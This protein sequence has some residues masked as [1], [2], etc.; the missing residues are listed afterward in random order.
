MQPTF[1]TALSLPDSQAAVS[2]DATAQIK[3]LCRDLQDYNDASDSDTSD[4]DESDCSRSIGSEHES[5]AQAVPRKAF[6]PPSSKRQQLSDVEAV[7]IFKLRPKPRKGKSLHRGSMLLCKSIAPKYGVSP[8][9]IRDIWRGRTWLH[10]TQHLW[11]EEDMLYKSQMAAKCARHTL[12]KQAGVGD[13]KHAA[14]A[15]PW[16]AAAAPH[17][18]FGGA[19]HASSLPSTPCPILGQSRM[20]CRSWPPTGAP[21]F[22]MHSLSSAI[23][24]HAALLESAGR[25]CIPSTPFPPPP[26][27]WPACAGASWPAEAA[28]AA[29]ALP[30]PPAV[31]PALL[32]L[33]SAAGLLG[34]GGVRV[35]PCG[36]GLG[37]GGPLSAGGCFGLAR[38]GL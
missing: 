28:A 35:G 30:P 3:K 14:V 1:E 9:T 21:A 29:L 25:R 20:L 32:L 4:L 16:A 2:S 17:H 7:E 18:G 13:E 12:H 24:S 22:P 23:A 11:T 5:D 31:D 26:S 15:A 27:P 34:A 10:A 36:L 33:L 19:S 38:P 6:K 8:K 37:A